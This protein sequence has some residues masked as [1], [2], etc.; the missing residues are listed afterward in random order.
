MRLRGVWFLIAFPRND[1]RI[2]ELLAA[3]RSSRILTR[4]PMPVE[5]T[6]QKIIQSCVLV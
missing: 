3:A 1:S 6:A 2:V 4:S 5:G